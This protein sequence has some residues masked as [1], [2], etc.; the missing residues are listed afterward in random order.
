MIRVGGG[1]SAVVGPNGQLV[2]GPVRD[3]ESILFADIDLGD[4][5]FMKQPC[6][7]AGHY[8]RPDVFSF[9][10][11]SP[12]ATHTQMGQVPSETVSSDSESATLSVDG[13]AL[14]APMTAG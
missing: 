1:W 13:P 9:S 2:A 8:A 5:I 12:A 6:D 10:L 4:I 14:T 7:S 11:L 3:E